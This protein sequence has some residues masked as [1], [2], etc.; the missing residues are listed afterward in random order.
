MSIYN[1]REEGIQKNTRR[2]QKL[3]GVEEWRFGQKK[4]EASMLKKI[5]LLGL[6]FVFALFGVVA[7]AAI[8]VCND[9]KC[10]ADDRTSVAI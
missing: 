5:T 2:R 1:Q 8:E 6:V 4:E 10:K 7:H 3:Y 9:L